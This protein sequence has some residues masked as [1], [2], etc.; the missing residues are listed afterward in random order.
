[1]K[2]RGQ[3]GDEATISACLIVKDEEE[4]LPDCLSSVKD[5]VDEIIVVDTGSSDRT[6]EIAKEYGAKIYEHPW[7]D[8]FAL[9]R[10]QSIEYATSEWV[11]I[12]DAD[13][14]FDA[15]YLT[16]VKELLPRTDFDAIALQ[17]N[18]IYPG[19]KQ[20][21]PAGIQRCGDSGVLR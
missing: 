4:L 6:I 3:K 16:K 7:E 17:V 15:G 14:R 18:N 1:M 12:I 21:D 19:T 5:L 9:H 11:F 13:E 20:G 8:N 10:N 2:S